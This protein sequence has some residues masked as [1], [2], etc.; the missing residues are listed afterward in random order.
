M[1]FQRTT[2]GWGGVWAIGL[3]SVR[4]SSPIRRSRNSTSIRECIHL[5]WYHRTLHRE[6]GRANKR[7]IFSDGDDTI[8]VI[9]GK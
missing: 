8:A 4:P 7:A 1:V 9:N 3:T 6:E 5:V 2:K